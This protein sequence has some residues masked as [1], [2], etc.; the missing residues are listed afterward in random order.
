MGKAQRD[1]YRMRRK[2]EALEYKTQSAF[3]KTRAQRYRDAVNGIVSSNTGTQNPSTGT[4]PNPSGWELRRSKLL[5][6][7]CDINKIKYVRNSSSNVPG[8]NMNLYLDTGVN[9]M[10]YL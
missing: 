2:A 7:S 10:E 8:R 5:F 1:I 4:D 6:P 3:K 9:F